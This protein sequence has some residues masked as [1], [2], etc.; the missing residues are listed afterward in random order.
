M[1]KVESSSLFSRFTEALLTRGFSFSW[2]SDR[3]DCGWRRYHSPL[4]SRMMVDDSDQPP[5]RP[6]RSWP[7]TPTRRRSGSDRRRTARRP[8]PLMRPQRDRTIPVAPS[9]PTETRRHREPRAPF[10][11]KARFSSTRAR[12]S[13]GV[14]SRSLAAAVVDRHDLV[15]YSDAPAAPRVVEVDQTGSPGGSV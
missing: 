15:C 4:P 3:P 13:C 2:R 7:M 6:E 9:A 14:R 12:C 5:A 11:R 10:P 8:D 1:Q